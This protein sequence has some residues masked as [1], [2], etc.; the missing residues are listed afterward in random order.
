MP[1]TVEEILRHADELAARFEAYEPDPHDELDAHAVGL[2]R[3]A[4][5]ERSGAERHLLQ[6]VQ[7]ARAAG[8]SWSAMG[9]MVGTSG[10]GCPAA[11]L[12]KIS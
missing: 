6:A 4:V 11:I 8:M 3:S 2:L 9:S 7:V 5:A 1:R 10:G 12:D